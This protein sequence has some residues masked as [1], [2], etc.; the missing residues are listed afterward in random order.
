MVTLYI[1]SSLLIKADSICD[2]SKG[3]EVTTIV[4]WIAVRCV[5]C[6][7]LCTHMGGL[8]LNLWCFSIVLLLNSY[9]IN[10]FRWS[11]SL[12]WSF[13]SRLG[14]LDS[15]SWGSSWLHLP[16]MGIPRAFHHLW[17]VMCCVC[18]YMLVYVHSPILLGVFGNLKQWSLREF[19][20][21]AFHVAPLTFSISTSL[22]RP[23]I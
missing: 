17:I 11:L 12:S 16:S 22:P 23:E 4:Y 19:N 15:E 2:Q 8:Q 20:F 1:F 7:C 10:F 13:S 3:L 5:F 6:M 21:L 14:L 9:L 18:V